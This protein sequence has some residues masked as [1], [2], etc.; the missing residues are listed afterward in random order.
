M[1]S[2][3]AQRTPAAETV[4]GAV[5]EA[6]SAAQ[7][8]AFTRED[9]S[10]RTLGDFR[11]LRRLG[12]GGMGQV[13]LA[14]QVSLQ[15][16]VAIKLLRPDFAQ[17]DTS[18]K[19]FDAEAKAIAQ[20]TH[21]NI[22]QVYFIGEEAGLKFM[23]LEYVEGMN[24][25]EYLQ[26]KG[27]PELPIAL[28][29][30]RQIAAAL[31]KASELGFMHRD[32]KPENVLLTRK[33]EVKVADFGLSRMVGEEVSLTQT[34]TTMGTPLYMSP[35]QVIGK[36]LDTRTDLYSF[37]ATCYHLLAGQ[38]PFIAE[39]AMAVG[40]RHLSDPPEPLSR[41]RPDLPEPLCQ[42]VHRLL[43][44]KPED[45]PQTAREVFREIRRIQTSLAGAAAQ[46]LDGEDVEDA[47]PPDPGRPA[48]APS[49]V[50]FP[51]ASLRRWLWPVVGASVAVAVVGGALVGLWLRADSSQASP[52]SGSLP[53]PGSAATSLRG[54]GN[55]M[56]LEKE[57]A[58]RLKI[59]ETKTPRDALKPGA[60]T[61]AER[62]QAGTRARA[63]LMSLYVFNLNQENI[64]RA[65]QFAEQ[66][67]LSNV[68]IYRSIG[69]VGEAAILASEK[70]AKESY[71]ALEHALSL[72]Q[73][74]L[75]KRSPMTSLVRIK[76]V[77]DMISWTLRLNEETAELP[78]ALKEVKEELERIRRGD[79]GKARPGNP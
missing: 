42:L 75:R 17:H 34:G 72:R 23:A 52:G 9:H 41:I 43:A 45:R 61:P 59:E 38:P 79:F 74:P 27:P 39:T 78:A 7:A 62:M 31:M 54:P 51:Q 50:S 12:E 37:G 76:E 8:G 2:L 49:S 56:F 63:E 66:E 53:R 55:A 64:A 25:K 69:F 58:L 35:E 16:R 15:R 24:L 46:D 6:S 4:G 36:P 29:I 14:E 57:K 3:D 47:S 26:K 20:L 60:D 10:G 73:T 21:P 30:M 68:E 18:R 32:I 33:V 5:L 44:K 28:A 40:L 71:E 22:V 11:L 19:R 13:Y 70:K 67:R 65:R 77:A 1:K 48:A